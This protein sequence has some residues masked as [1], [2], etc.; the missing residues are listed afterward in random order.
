MRT[1]FAFVFLALV[2][3][4]AAFSCAP[5]QQE[6]PQI[7]PNIIFI[8]A[9]DLGYADLSCFGRKD[10]QT[11]VLDAFVRRGLKFSNAYAAA[12]VCTPTRVALMTG[13]FPART[14]VGLREP[15]RGA[16]FDINMGLSPTIPTLSSLLK[17]SGYETALFGK[18]HL[19][20][21][22]DFFPNKHGF[23]HFFGIT[24]GA[25]DYIDH[26]FLNDDQTL[27]ENYEPVQKDGYLTDLITDYAVGFIQKKHTKPFFI[28]LE[29]TA[30]HWPW[31]APGDESYPESMDFREG[32]SAETYAKM[33]KSLDTNIGRVLAAIKDAG[34]DETTLIIF[35]SD[36]GGER[37]SDMG[38]F[39][40]HK[41]ELWE[42]G[43]RVPAA[44]QWPGVIKPNS[45]S[46]QPV[47]TMDWTVTML[48]AAGVV[49]P[50]E[51]TFD[52]MNL[53]PLLKG[54]SSLVPRT[55][56][57]RTSN[58][59]RA[60]ALRDD[61]WKYLRNPQGEYLFNLDEDPYETENLKD[62]D[63]A[64][65]ERLRKKFLGIDSNMLPPYFLPTRNREE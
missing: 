29:Y 41:M 38:P 64:T 44:A 22:P 57:W 39:K 62:R 42:G 52:G 2:M 25:A 34:L 21:N 43:I 8:M 32:G 27:Y 31:Q 36:N 37:Y 16:P 5:H 46:D 55:F 63:P 10:F 56:Y 7:R 18:W 59:I 54:D 50:R 65:M 4:S 47:I 33:V 53:L 11:P 15:L 60:D 14:D 3:L 1:R 20:F 51:V 49:I 35:T 24:A 30:P 9:D 48:A 28:N 12:P 13:R 19:G 26:K 17:E 40:G 58:E 45:E 61:N 6:A 23:D